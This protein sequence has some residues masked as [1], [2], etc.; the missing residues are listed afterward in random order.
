MVLALW[1]TENEMRRLA[2]DVGDERIGLAISDGLGLTA[3][4]LETVRRVSGSAS[5]ERIAQI[6]AS[7]EVEEIVVGLP[8]LEDGSEGKQV[9]STRAYVRGLVRYVDLPIA[10]FDERYSSNDAQSLIE[11]NKGR[12]R[13]RNRM[14]SAS[15][16]AV[17]AA[18]FLQLY[19]DQQRQAESDNR[20]DPRV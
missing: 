4:P 18:V 17:A 9:A 5:F 2:L 6:I 19:L 10:Y 13:R 8:L 20:E 3:R 11:R 12:R 1:R 7:E 14:G 15:I 16:D